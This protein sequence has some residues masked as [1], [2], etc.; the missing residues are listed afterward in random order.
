VKADNMRDKICFIFS[1]Y[2]DISIYLLSLN[3]KGYTIYYNSVNTLFQKGIRKIAKITKTYFK[4]FSFLIWRIRFKNLN[5][6]SHIVVF[7]Y[8]IE[9][10]F[11]D[12]IEHNFP[13]KKRILFYDNTIR[14]NAK[15]E[16]EIA[17]Y[18][19]SKWY[20]YSYDEVDCSF[21]NIIYN[22]EFIMGQY[23]IDKSHD[24]LNI[25][26]RIFFIGRSKDR[27][28]RLSLLKNKFDE[29][30][31]NNLI[32][33][34]DE[35]DSNG[36]GSFLPYP[37]VLKEVK[38]SKILLDVVKDKQAGMTQRELESLYFEKKLVTDNRYIKN[39]DYYNE[40]N[41]FLIDYSM[42]DILEGLKEFLEKPFVPI[43]PQ[44]I[45]NYTIEAWIGRFMESNS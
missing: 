1:E 12:F 2:S 24:G 32:I 11:C 31:I 29:L 40:N 27:E 23:L 18:K 39:R 14:G 42:P 15:I 36:S 16:D 22:P 26:D 3:K 28:E 34:I 41:I 44:I 4:F 25:E 19:R 5:S 37:E 10:Y 20:I 30:K 8:T 43:D 9:Q 45:K 21:F 13:T 17:L 7:D 35:N 6:Y 38:K 33:S